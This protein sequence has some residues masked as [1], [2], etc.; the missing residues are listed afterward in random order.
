MALFSKQ[1][2]PMQLVLQMRQQGITDNQI[3]QT[4]QKQGFSTQQVF[5]AMSQADLA[6]ISPQPDM[7][8]PPEDYP[9][10]QYAQE[11]AYPQSHVEGVTLPEDEHIHEVAEAVVSEKWEELIGEV[12]KIVS[13]KE[14]V[15]TDLQKLKDAVSSLKEEF[16]QLRQGVLGKIGEYDM[17]MRDVSSELKA[18]EGVFK[19]VIPELTESVAELSRM[20]KS[21]KKK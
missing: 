21:M 1:Q 19:D 2:S 8:P 13:W 5:D 15:E 14:S 11:S 4:L 6:N 12:K 9:Q 20:S 3:V 18:V 16:N 17:H 7:P 10:E